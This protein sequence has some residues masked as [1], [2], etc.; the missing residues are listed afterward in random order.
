MA[1][2]LFTMHVLHLYFTSAVTSRSFRLTP[3]EQIL[4]THPPSAIQMVMESVLQQKRLKLHWRM[5]SKKRKNRTTNSPALATKMVMVL[6]LPLNFSS[7]VTLPTL[8]ATPMASMTARRSLTVPRRPTLPTRP[9]FRCP[10]KTAM[11]CLTSSRKFSVAIQMIRMTQAMAVE[12][13]RV[14]LSIRP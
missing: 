14:S 4:L 6:I 7:A 11:V 8:T 12:W 9:I 3:M 10:T 13:T 1:H 2:P 5:L